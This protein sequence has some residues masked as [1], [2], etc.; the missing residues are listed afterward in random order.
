[1]A[2]NY[3]REGPVATRAAARAEALARPWLAR[4]PRPGLAL[5]PACLRTLTG[6][7]GAVQAVALSRDGSVA[8]SGGEDRVLKVWDVT[9]G[10][11][12]ASLEA[13]TATIREL[14]LDPDGKVAV[15]ASIDGTLR[16]W[17][18]RSGT[19]S[20]TLRTPSPMG[21]AVSADSTRATVGGSAKLQVW[22]LTAGA[23]VREL[24]GRSD[25]L[26]AALAEA[27]EGWAQMGGG[28][29]PDISTAVAMTPDG[30]QAIATG[31]DGSCPVLR[32][33][34]LETG[35]CSREI[36]PDSLHEIHSI[37]M[38]R[39]GRTMAVVD[40]GALTFV[41]WDVPAGAVVR[42][43][44][45]A[46]NA[47]PALGHVA[48]ILAVAL[49][50][51]G[52]LAVSASQDHTLRVWEV[53]TGRCLRVLHGHTDAVTSVALS[54]GADRAISASRD[55]TLRVWDLSADPD[56]EPLERHAG[57]LTG[58]AL[59]A[60]GARAVSYFGGPYVAPP[61]HARTHA[62]GGVIWP[63]EFTTPQL[64]DT[65]SGSCA[66][67]LRGHETP[68]GALVLTPDGRTA[69]TVDMPGTVPYID[70]ETV[71][72]W[73][74][75]SATRLR[76]LRGTT[77]D[78]A[79]TRG[80]Y[81]VAIS[82]DGRHALIAASHRHRKEDAVHLVREWDL[83]TGRCR[84]ELRGHDYPVTRIAASPDGRLA[85]TADAEEY[86]RGGV[87]LRV[88]D[89]DSGEC[90]RTLEGGLEA[91][92]GLV[93][94]PDGMALVW[95]SGSPRL[96]AFQGDDPPRSIGN[97]DGVDRFALTPQGHTVVAATS[98]GTLEVLDLVE[99]TRRHVLTGHA[100][101]RIRGLAITGDGRLA[102][103]AST[104]GT[105]RVWD[106]AT[107]AC[108]AIYPAGGPLVALSRIHADGKCVAGAHDGGLHFLTLR[109]PRA[110]PPLVTAAA[111]GGRRPG[112]VS[113]LAARL[114]GRLGPGE[115][116]RA[117]GGRGGAS[118][119]TGLLPLARCPWCASIFAVGSPAL[120]AIRE[121][122]RD[123]RGDTARPPCLALPASRWEGE[124]L[125]SGCTHCGRPLR[126]NPFLADGSRAGLEGSRGGVGRIS[127]SA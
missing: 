120:E 47:D 41:A 103:S 111:L 86:T 117:G 62:K 34:D 19:L 3:A 64:W 108:E 104:D 13:H 35:T 24:K 43:F 20:R 8:I 31:H 101:G 72:V 77:S 122:E 25:E 116:L 95:S 87:T 44:G 5:R 79:I 27:S 84:R 92:S 127:P 105:L 75:P 26:D 109:D 81:A 14:V 126:F 119:G 85:A 40:E 113:R 123:L 50:D 17:D 59:A 52:S 16:V 118:T 37:A 61:S 11:C 102:A 76:R 73:D 98:R 10:A 69:V 21:L 90:L 30:R 89:L 60:D 74:F 93:F 100:P 39:D 38:S 56:P 53:G 70:E 112:G 28:V 66:G 42:A 36:R 115:R 58:T 94:T 9:R 54:A 2:R 88:W 46:Y 65:A 71:L 99:G 57:G 22:D 106:L 48:E 96:W 45:A 63:E 49:S 15:S 12:M 91:F 33:W 1:M 82:P 83:T 121:S 18:L 114:Q 51:D 97:E 55:A 4:D 29:P 107:G 6:H 125:S 124:R 80:E 67:R 110:R 23:L 7:R 78:A 68:I 32:F